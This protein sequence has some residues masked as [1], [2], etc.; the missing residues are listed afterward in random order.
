MYSR[1]RRL[2]L[3]I[4]AAIP[5]LAQNSV[6]RVCADP[7]NLPFSN[8]QKQ[9]FENKLADLLAAG[10][11]ARLEYTWWSQRKSFAKKSLDQ[12]ACEVVLGVPTSLPDVLTTRV[13]YRSTY[14]FVTRHDRNL[15]VASLADPRLSTLRIGIHVV[16]DNYA[17]PAFALARLGITQNVVGFSLFGEYGQPNPPRKLIDA[18]ETGAVDVAIVWGPFAGY[19][20]QG[21][22][23]PLDIAPVAPS[24]FGGVPF[25]YEI[26]AAVR[27]GNNTLKTELDQILQSQ[28]AAVHK[29][30]EQYAVPQVP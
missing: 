24:T 15:H 16:D 2:V 8:Q 5:T 25:T 22:P 17:P 27:E 3:L 6:L 26:S 29:I 10:A 18:V 4:L 19:F 12:G 7:N 28:S 1:C 11:N 14:V 13:Y 9:G 20:S 23:L 30:L 21:A